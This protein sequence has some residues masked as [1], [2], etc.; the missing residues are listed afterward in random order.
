MSSIESLL[1]GDIQLPSPPAVAIRILESVKKDDAGYDEL[2]GIISSDPALAAKILK[3][4]NSSAYALPQKVESI[5][6]AIAVL[7]V[8]ALKNIALSFVMTKDLQGGQ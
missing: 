6:K 1:K 7:G 2:A 3:V 8:N 4:A 5:Q